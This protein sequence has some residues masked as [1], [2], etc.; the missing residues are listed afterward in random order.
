T[1]NDPKVR[2]P[3][4]AVGL[5]KRACEIADYQNPGFLDTL[6]AAYAA[7]ERFDDAVSTAQ[8]ALQMI[9]SGDKKERALEVQ[10]RLDLYKQN[11]SYRQP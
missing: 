9:A 6:A 10:K 4:E 8:K 5:A 1:H 11:K 3:A 2:N 7:N